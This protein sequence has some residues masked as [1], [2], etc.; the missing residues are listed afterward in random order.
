MLVDG[1]EKHS[2]DSEKPS[3]PSTVLA[4]GSTVTQIKFVYTGSASNPVLVL[5]VLTCEGVQV[6][7][8]SERQKL[9][10]IAVSAEAVIAAFRSVEFI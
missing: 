6:W 2:G 5:I 3:T 10:S 9:A 4:C 7:E 1:L 8:P